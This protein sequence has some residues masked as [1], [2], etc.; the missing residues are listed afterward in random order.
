MAV[1]FTEGQDWKGE[2]CSAQVIFKIPFPDVKDRRVARRLEFKN[3]RWYRMEALK[4]TIQ[5]YG[6]AVRTPS[7]SKPTYVVDLS[8]LDLIRNMKKSLPDWFVEA[9]PE[10][11]KD[12]VEVRK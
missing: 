2:I 7:E 5:A 4:E 11:W 6:R 3:W 10:H 12:F 8:F 1:S 9:L